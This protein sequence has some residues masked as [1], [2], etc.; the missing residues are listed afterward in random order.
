MTV[1][2]TRF[3]RF[4]AL[5]KNLSETDSQGRTADFFKTIWVMS[6]K[7][8]RFSGK[9]LFHNLVTRLHNQQPQSLR[10]TVC[11]VVMSVDTPA[12]AA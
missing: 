10:G 7:K 11:F 5:E 3:F 4:D 9:V 2:T 1:S 12:K 8:N 6:R